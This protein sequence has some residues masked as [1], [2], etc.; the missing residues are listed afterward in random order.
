MS[1]RFTNHYRFPLSVAIMLRTPNECGGEGEG[2]EQR[3]WWNISR[4]ETKVVYG[5][6]MEDLSPWW[7]YYAFATDGGQWLGDGRW[8]S[9]VPNAA[10]DLCWGH[11]I[12]GPTLRR[13]DYVQLGVD[14]PTHTVTLF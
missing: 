9:A 3:G 12:S 6:D 14:T 10:F 7:Y 4:G 1:F 8:V 11:G 5:G 2:W 13:V